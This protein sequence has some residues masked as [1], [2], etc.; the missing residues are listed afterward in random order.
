MPAF[1]TPWWRA[2]PWHV[3]LPW[4]R[5]KK[6][7][8]KHRSRRVAGCADTTVPDPPPPP[9]PPAERRTRR[10]SF[11]EEVRRILPPS[12]DHIQPRLRYQAR[13]APQAPA[14]CTA[15]CDTTQCRLQRRAVQ[16][17]T[18]ATPRTAGARG[19]VHQGQQWHLARTR[20]RATRRDGTP[21]TGQGCGGGG[22]GAAAAG[23]ARIARCVRGA[24]G[25]THH[26]DTYYYGHT[27][28]RTYG[29]SLHHKV[30]AST[31]CGYSVH[32]MRLQATPKRKPRASASA[33]AES[34]AALLA[35]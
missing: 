14:R 12:G 27:T 10:L 11:N 26:G 17:A 25:T 22:G 29:H 33:A 4:E 30:A 31:T 24:A 1:K 6:T 28:T 32:N 16:A 18:P 7:L 23:H 13:S 15:G 9:P 2:A 19:R 3:S 8:R 20:H 35:A 5:P 34:I 21:R